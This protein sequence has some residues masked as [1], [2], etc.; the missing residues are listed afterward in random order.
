MVAVRSMGL[1]FESLVGHQV[2]GIRQRLVTPAYLQTLVQLANERFVE[3]TKRIKRFQTAFHDAMSAPP[4]KMNP[5]GEEW[6]DATAR[7]ERKRAEGLR[8]KA[9]LQAQKPVK[10]EADD[11]EVHGLENLGS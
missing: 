6:E 11:D 8:R 10:R 5:D 3:N 2:N 9:E 7:R 4:P 1:G